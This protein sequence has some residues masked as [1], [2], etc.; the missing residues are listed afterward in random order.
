M[1]FYRQEAISISMVIGT[2]K[3]SKA[4]AGRRLRDMEKQGLIKRE[5]KGPATRYIQL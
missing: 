3:I 4:T 5:G 1:L 2:L